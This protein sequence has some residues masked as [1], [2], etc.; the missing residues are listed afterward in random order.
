M[1]YILGG[2]LDYYDIKYHEKGHPVVKLEIKDL[3][4]DWKLRVVA[5]SPLF[6]PFVFTALTIFNINFLYVLA[7]LA[8][9]YKTTLPSPSDFKVAGLQVPKF[10]EV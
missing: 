6:T 8:V 10:L 5:M 4:K 1:A 7:Y 3:N 2:K 9:F